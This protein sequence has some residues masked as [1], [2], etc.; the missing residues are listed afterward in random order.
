LSIRFLPIHLS[1]ASL[2]SIL[3]P[4]DLLSLKIDVIEMVDGR[5]G[6]CLSLHQVHAHV[7]AGRPAAGRVLDRSFPFLL[8][9]T[10]LFDL[11]IL[12]NGD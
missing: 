5:E 4:F 8:Y 10:I 11:I 6:L 9:I 7:V 2:R 12:W 1:L 3:I